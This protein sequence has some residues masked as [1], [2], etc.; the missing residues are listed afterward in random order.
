MATLHILRSER[1]TS[2]E[3]LM[4]ALPDDEAAKVIELYAADI[5]WETVVDDIFSYDNVICWW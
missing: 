1:D 2:T 3:A 4:K 5:D